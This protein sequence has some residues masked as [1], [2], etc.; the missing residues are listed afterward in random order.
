MGIVIRQSTKS[1]F[2]TYIGV[3]IGVINTLW[4]LPYALTEEQLGLYRAI[5]SA[6]ILF[7]TFASFGSAN[8]PF[9]FFFYFKD[10]KNRHN[11]ILFFILLLGCAGFLVFTLFFLQF[12]YLFVSAFMRNAP[13]IL[14]YYFPLIFF[15]FILLFINI[16]ESYNIIQQNPVIPIFSREILTRGFLSVGLLLFLFC[17]F[18]YYYLILIFIGSYGIIL[19]FLIYY[20]KTQN[21]LFVKPDLRIFKSPL[22]KEMFVFTGL[23]SLGNVSGIIITNID[24]LMLSA[25]SGLKSTGIYSISFF[26]AA[27]IAVPKKALSQVL[28]PMVSEANKNND[29]IKINELY[30]K[31]SITQLVI[32]G[33]LFLLI[34]LNIENI[35]K[36]IPHGSIYSQGKWV[37]FIIGL[38]YIF[39]MTTGINQEIVGTSKYYKIDLLFYPILGLIAIGANMFLVPRYGMIGA[40][41]ATAFTIFLL[42]TV[43]FFFLLLIFKIQPFSFNTIK[44]LSIFILVIIINYFIPDIHNHFLYDIILRSSVIT[45][46]FIFLVISLKTSEDINLTF[47]KLNSKI[48]IIYNSFKR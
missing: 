30:K 36:L 11:G 8:L 47:Y 21:Y 40:A 48:R 37:V 13:L 35:F 33:F 46:V 28:I 19:L 41:M 22:L 38:G 20:T 45:A 43:R 2:I 25:Y 15:T 39:D 3:G 26:I 27:F 14:N 34:W 1:V 42:N 10:Y 6:A 5:I 44:A 29:K 32:G 24:S 17:K 7:A 12:R 16:F 31:S 9:R 18:T 4:L 23:I